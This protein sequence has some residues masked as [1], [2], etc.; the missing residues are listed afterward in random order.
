MYIHHMPRMVRKQVY[1][2]AAQDQSLRR[3]AVIGR[4][5]DAAI[6]REALDRH[7]GGQSATASV[8]KDPLWDLVGLGES[9]S[10]DLSERVDHHVYGRRKR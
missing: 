10:G 5:S 1:L 2:T 9:R 7:L 6:I 3:A 4:C 8:A